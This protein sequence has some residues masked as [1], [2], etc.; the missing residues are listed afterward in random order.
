LSPI[1]FLVD[2]N[3]SVALP[4]IAHARGYEATHVNFLGLRQAKDWDILPVILAEDWILV[5][6]NV[7]EFRW[8]YRKLDIHPGV[9]LV[10]PVV[11]REEQLNLF[12]R[13]LD[14]IDTSPDMTN[15]AIEVPM[16]EQRIVIA[17]FNL[18]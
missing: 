8:R 15:I 6:C 4:S 13:V 9:V 16:S 3:L 17:R 14:T 18:P 1:R 2:E 7:L 12:G 5:T 11:P 10:V